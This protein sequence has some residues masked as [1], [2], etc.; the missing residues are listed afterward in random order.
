MSVDDFLKRTVIEAVDDLLKKRLDPFLQRMHLASTLPPDQDISLNRE[1]AAAYLG[2]AK[3]TLAIMASQK[4]GPPYY[5]IGRSVRYRKSDLAS[6]LDENRCL[7]GRR[8]RP[9]NKPIAVAT[10]GS[11]H[12]RLKKD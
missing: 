9:A 3:T 6:F 7:I 1:Q 2:L 8:G 4:R 10:N 5:K 11:I 12:K